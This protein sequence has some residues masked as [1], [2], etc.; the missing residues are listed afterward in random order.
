MFRNVFSGCVSDR[1]S[2]AEAFRSQKLKFGASLSSAL[3]HDYLPGPLVDILV[4]IAREGVLTTDVFRRPGN[5]NDTRRIVKRLTEGKQV[6]Y[7]N[8]SFYT[9]ASVVKKFLLKIPGG[10]FTP[11]GEEHLLQVLAIGPKVEQIESVHSFMETLT[12]AHQQL[13]TML[14]GTWYRIVTYQ[15]QNCMSV[16]ALSRSVAGSM[17]HTCAEDP[18]KVERASRIMQFLIDNFGVESMFGQDNVRFFVETTHTGLHIQELFHYGYVSE[19]QRIPPGTSEFIEMTRMEKEEEEEDD[20]YEDRGLGR[21]REFSESPQLS[22]TA[23]RHSRDEIHESQLINTSTLSAP[24]VSLVPS[25]EV[26]KRPKSLE[27][28][29]N[30]VRSHYQSRCLSRFNSVKRKQLERL[31]QRSDWFLSPTVRERNNSRKGK[32]EWTL[33]QFSSSSGQSSGQH[34]GNG[35]CDGKTNGGGNTSS[36]GN[37]K[38][39]QAK[40]SGNSVVTKASSEGAVLEAFSDGDSVFTDN[41]SRSE[42]PASEPVWSHILKVHS[43]DIIHSDTGV[44]APLEMSLYGGSS[45]ADLSIDSHDNISGQHFGDLSPPLLRSKLVEEEEQGTKGDDEEEDEDNNTPTGIQDEE[46]TIMASSSLELHQNS[47]TDKGSACSQDSP[48]D[49][50][51]DSGEDTKLKQKEGGSSAKSQASSIETGEQGGLIQGQQ[52]Q[53]EQVG[54]ETVVEAAV[55]ATE[56]Q[57]QAELPEEDVDRLSEQTQ[58]SLV[59]QSSGDSITDS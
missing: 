47:S 3:K 14:F 46:D 28:N 37:S 22:P 9:L 43:R 49:S 13:I 42:S 51:G 31:R 11:E 26:S 29:L 1:S 36:K 19:A 10:I 32:G 30:E 18:A 4:H 59:K 20:E 23:L 53:H 55:A 57:E 35:N 17:F 34:R 56:G 45:G 21:E 2:Q 8:Y 12:R 40:T 52:T 54:F 50:F 25:P 7:A 44:L 39:L 48:I 16:E 38:V 27:D 58:C 33:S 6:I 5:P 41:T 15:D 24:E